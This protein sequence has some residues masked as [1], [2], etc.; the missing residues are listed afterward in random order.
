MAYRSIDNLVADLIL[1]QV[2]D[3]VSLLK[4]VEYAIWYDCFT[5]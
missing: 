4:L 5:D 1:A 2:E 3:P